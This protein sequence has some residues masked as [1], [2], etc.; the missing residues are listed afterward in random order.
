MIKERSTI[1]DTESKK[2]MVVEYNF[3]THILHN[4]TLKYK[5]YM[6]LKDYI[7]AVKASVIMA[8]EKN[9][10]LKFEKLEYKN[11][12]FEII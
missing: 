5:E 1:T 8:K 2:S 10:N 6:E 11:G 9:Y 4:I 12:N 3:D 7:R